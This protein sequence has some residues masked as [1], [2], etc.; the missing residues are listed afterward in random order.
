MLDT[1]DTMPPGPRHLHMVRP[2]QPVWVDLKLVYPFGRPQARVPDGLD[3]TVTVPGML[4]MWR[5]TT[6]GHWV[7]WVSF[8]LGPE[9]QG[10]TP[11]TQ[12]VPADALSPREVRNPWS[13]SFPYERRR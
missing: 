12:W 6:T 11:H 1:G 13:G 10:A 7:G 9:G 8:K 4:G 3:L 5:A 2:N